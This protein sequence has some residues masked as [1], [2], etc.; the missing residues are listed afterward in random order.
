[1]NYSC[2]FEHKGIP[3]PVLAN[4]QSTNSFTLFSCGCISDN[5][6][7]KSF[8]NNHLKMKS[9]ATGKKIKQSNGGRRPFQKRGESEKPD[10]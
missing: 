8:S 1:M 2:L 4:K 6:F 9:Y 7:N 10:E 5:G 3:E